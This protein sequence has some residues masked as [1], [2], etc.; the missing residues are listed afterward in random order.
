MAANTSNSMDVDSESGSQGAQSSPPFYGSKKARKQ[1][2]IGGAANLPGSSRSQSAHRGGRP[3]KPLEHTT[4]EDED[5]DDTM[6]GMEATGNHCSHGQQVANKGMSSSAYSFIPSGANAQYVATQA[7]QAPRRAPPLPVLYDY[8][9]DRIAKTLDPIAKLKEAI[10]DFENKHA[11]TGSSPS[12]ASGAL[13]FRIPLFSPSPPPMMAS[14]QAAGASS[15]SSANFQGYTQHRKEALDDI[16]RNMAKLMEDDPISDMAFANMHYDREEVRKRMK[17]MVGL[18]K[19]AISSI[20]SGMKEHSKN[21]FLSQRADSSA[22]AQRKGE[23]LPT[24]AYIAPEVDK[25]G[26]SVDNKPKKP[27]E[28]AAKAVK[29]FDKANRDYDDAFERCLREIWK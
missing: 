29:D 23:K 13:P 21:E 22:H 24:Y 14:S 2:S 1:S 26:K 19:A 15:V 4:V 12:A 28:V 9:V 18:L 20:E 27:E 17:E 16:H 10:E 8:Q 3:R 7:P 6:E 5:D 11:A 25:D